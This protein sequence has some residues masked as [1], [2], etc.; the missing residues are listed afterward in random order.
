MKL[1]VEELKDEPA[2]PLDK[3]IEIGHKKLSS[4]VSEPK[5]NRTKADYWRLGL[6]MFLIFETMFIIP[7]LI[8]LFFLGNTFKAVKGQQFKQARSAYQKGTLF[9][10]VGQGL[11]HLSKPALSF[12]YLAR[13]PDKTVGM[14]ENGYGLAGDLLSSTDTLPILLQVFNSK[15]SLSQSSVKTHL[16]DFHDSLES[17]GRHA[18]ALQLS[19]E[20]LPFIKNKNDDLNTLAD[21]LEDA[22]K[23]SAHLDSLLGQGGKAT[24]IVFFYNNMELRPGG[25]FLGSLALVTL[26]KY[27]LKEFTVFD[28]YDADGQLKFHVSPPSPISRYL[29]QPHY[30]LRD[31]AFTPDFPQNVQAARF[32][33]KEELGINDFDGALGLTTT[34]MSQLLEAFAPIHLPDFDTIVNND[35]FYLLAQSHAE[36]SYFPGSKRKKGFLSALSRQLFLKLSEADMAQLAKTLRQNLD[37]KQLVIWTENEK[38]ENEL[39][40]LRWGGTLISPLCVVKNFSCLVNHLFPVDANLGVNKANIFVE[41]KI[42][43][44]LKLTTD[45]K[46]I[47]KVDFVFKNN[48]PKDTF[49]GGDY[50]NYFQLYLPADAGNISVKV[51]NKDAQ[52][53][54][55]KSSGEYKVIGLP[56]SIKATQSSTLTIG[57]ENN[58]LA[59]S[60]RFLYQLMVQKQI[61]LVNTDYS[62]RVDLP[63]NSVLIDSNF[64]PVA[65][66]GLVI[67]NTML[68]KDKL[69]LFEIERS[70]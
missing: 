17:A 70:P 68:T 11:Y 13:L 6:L 47:N 3:S 25:G 69:F 53:Y 30:Y 61:G 59:P 2:K 10:T 29:K 51:N 67:Y 33:L 40:R 4:R 14:I 32:F 35:N 37:E 48:S 12:F 49:P 52:S 26:D 24:Y 55:L 57:Y 5:K 7:L 31:S 46:F 22:A 20:S 15:S 41:R 58:D 56:I 60:G 63:N 9:L 21:G 43:H 28:V 66:T 39:S 45:G 27:S 19:A 36:G 54:D 64:E 18:R 42:K 23:I 62:L 8:S 44:H 50:L 65:K 38:V 1:I 34:G 16:N